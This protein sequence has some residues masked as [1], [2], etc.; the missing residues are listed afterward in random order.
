MKI[1]GWSYKIKDF[2]RGV[3]VKFQKNRG[4]L[5]D[6]R[7]KEKKSCSYIERLTLMFPPVG[8]VNTYLVFSASICYEQNLFCTKQEFRYWLLHCLA[9]P[10]LTNMLCKIGLDR[11]KWSILMGLLGLWVLHS[12]LITACDITMLIEMPFRCLMPDGFALY[13][14]LNCYIIIIVTWYSNNIVHVFIEINVWATLCRSPHRR[15]KQVSLL[16]SVL[17]RDLRK[18]MSFF[19]VT[20]IR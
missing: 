14:I 4:K 6:T 7:L 5:E 9:H 8:T 2:G 15:K 3:H 20:C 17:C 19:A 18:R 13:R 16:P 12:W 11:D 10:L 1:W